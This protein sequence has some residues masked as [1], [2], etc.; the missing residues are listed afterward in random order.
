MKF[1]VDKR[2]TYTILKPELEKL[3]TT[4]APDLKTE[5]IN[6]NAEGTKHIILDLSQVKYVDSSGLSSILVANRLCGNND[7]ALILAALNEHVSKLITIS[8]LNE[9]LNIVPTVEEAVEAVHLH[10]LESDIKSE[11]KGKA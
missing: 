2:D 10:E 8:Q 1:S 5:F 3:D 7:G 9:V 4:A 11:E 6:L